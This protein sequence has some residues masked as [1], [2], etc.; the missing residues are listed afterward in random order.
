DPLLPFGL[1]PLRCINDQGRVVSLNK[2]SYWID[3]KASQKENQIYNL[4]L[5]LHED[6]K[7]Q[8]EITS[9]SFGYAALN[10]RKKI[11]SFN[12]TDE[13]VENLDEGMPKIKI[14]KSEIEN[15]DNLDKAVVEKYSV[16][17][18]AYSGL[19]RE[20]F[21]F[22]PFFMDRQTE[23]PFKLTERSF[24]VDW[25]APSE[26]K[27]ILSLNFPEEFEVV[28]PPDRSGLTLPD[29]GGMYLTNLELRP[30]QLTFS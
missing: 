26:S 17:I 6:G 3:L 16:E 1:L 8:G 28:S 14:I 30:G 23:N 4:N 15:L 24:P 11:K 18:D 19:D 2:P 22:N 9:F 20:Q 25:G 27:L 10:K 13:Y 7:I 5:T 12:S 29:N 21:L